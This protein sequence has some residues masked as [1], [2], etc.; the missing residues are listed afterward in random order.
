[1]RKLCGVAEGAERGCDDVRPGRRR[2]DQ[3]QAHQ[4]VAVGG[5]LGQPLR[6]D[7]LVSRPGLGVTGRG[8]LDIRLSQCDLQ[9]GE[10]RPL[11]RLG[12]GDDVL[13]RRRVAGGQPVQVVHVHVL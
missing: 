12:L 9:V 10:G 13:A 3:G 2:L 6:Q 11:A 8:L 5:A 4:C 7:R 1:M